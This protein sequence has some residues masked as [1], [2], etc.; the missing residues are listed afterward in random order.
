[1]IDQFTIRR[2][3][4]AANIVDV[5]RELGYDLRR[6]SGSTYEC[7]CPFHEDR[8]IGS[9]KISE[10]KNIYKC[11]SCD[12]SGGPV[13]FLIEKEEMSFL[14][15]IRFLGRMYGIEVEGAEHFTPTAHTPH[16]PPP[17]LPT[18]LLPTELVGR[19]MQHVEDNTLAKWFRTLAWDDTQRAR[20]STVMWMYGVGNW[21]DSRTVFWQVDEKKQL[22]TGKI[23]KYNVD[24]H[25]DK[26]THPSWAHVWKDVA[27]DVSNYEVRKT[28]FGMHLT[29]IYPKAKINIV[30]SEKTALLC[31]ITYGNFTDTLWLASGGKACLNPEVLAPLTDAKRDISL[32]P[33]K[34]AVKEWERIAKDLGCGVKCKS[35]YITQFWKE[36]D[37]AK[38]DLGDMMVRWLKEREEG[39][40]HI[41]SE[42]ERL[43]DEYPAFKELVKTFDL[44]E[45]KSQ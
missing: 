2:V 10:A 40:P 28:L 35:D 31:S 25:R 21:S 20:I 24:G 6:S 7:L 13:D 43:C 44:H 11:F 26:E 17:P 33:D 30:E 37:G 19:F 8:R 12:H 4:D 22:R 3:K 9:F 34:D 36:E 38:A 15:A 32:F 45:I 42:V 1:M 16:T 18:L 41:R 14:D 29:G 27:G 5:M 23:M 39:R